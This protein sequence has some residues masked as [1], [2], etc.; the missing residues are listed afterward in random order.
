VSAWTAERVEANTSE[1]AGRAIRMDT[2]RR[3]ALYEDHPELIDERLQE[4]DHE[5]DIERVIEAEGAATTLVGLLLGARDRR[6]LALPLFV[7]AMMALHAVHGFYPLLSL[8][9]RA[10]LR[11]QREIGDER[12]ALL[13]LRGDW[14]ALEGEADPRRRAELAYQPTSLPSA[15]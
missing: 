5:W 13:E 6:W 14:S 10:G 8:L 1:A 15:R 12:R 7:Q 9:R 2:Q 3:L 4:L 11:T